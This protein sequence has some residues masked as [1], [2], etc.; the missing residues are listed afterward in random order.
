[1]IRE[2]NLKHGFRKY[3]SPVSFTLE[4][5]NLGRFNKKYLTHLFPMHPCSTLRNSCGFLMFSRDREKVIWEQ[6]G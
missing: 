3:V 1:M 6:I 2:Y 5:Y 4:F